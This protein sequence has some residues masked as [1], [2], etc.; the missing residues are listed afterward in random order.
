MYVGAESLLTSGHL[1]DLQDDLFP[2]R[3]KWY[4]IGLRIGL[5][6]GDLDVIK[7]QYRD[8]FKDCLREMLKLRLSRARPL[9]AA[10]VIAALRKP[11]V[12]ERGSSIAQDLEH[13]CGVPS[14]LDVCDL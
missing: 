4:D 2:V 5:T 7:A 12:G 3:D 8:D 14:E 6:C 13:K 10:D 11:A 9:N 1:P